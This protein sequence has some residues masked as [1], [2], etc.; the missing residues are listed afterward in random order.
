MGIDLSKLKLIDYEGAG[1]RTPVLD[2]TSFIQNAK[3]PM[4]VRR[5]L[6][7]NLEFR[8]WLKINGMRLKAD[9]IMIYYR[10]LNDD[11]DFVTFVG[12]PNSSLGNSFSEMCGNGIRALALHIMLTANN[13]E[14]KKY[15]NEGIRI[16]A[17]SVKILKIEEFNNAQ[18]T[19]M[20]SVNLGKIRITAVEL[21]P[22]INIDFFSQSNLSN[23]TLQRAP[24]E[25]LKGR[26]F[27]IGFN[28]D[29]SGEPHIV[30]LNDENQYM[31]LIESFNLSMNLNRDTIINNL[32]LIVSCFGKRITFNEDYFPHG[33]NFNLA[34]VLDKEIYMSTH[35]RNMSLGQSDCSAQID[36]DG[37][38]KCNTL[39][40]GTGGSIASAVAIIQGYIKENKIKTYHPG[41]EIYYKVIDEESIMTGPASRIY[42]SQKELQSE[43]LPL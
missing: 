20:I 15:L 21:S 3:D 34:L 38:C 41:G 22:Y 6:E 1:N 14:R 40:C 29:T 7:Q 27:G 11:H 25:S 19:A 4:E 23:I 18:K 9:S 42:E 35:E 5:D 33:I 26:E 2:F 8:K 43:H 17:G 36:R 39:A 32:R 28:G 30:L 31:S 24:V 12:E 13:N 16:W 10:A 37:F